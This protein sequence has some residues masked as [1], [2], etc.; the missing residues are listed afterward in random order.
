[1]SL[2]NNRCLYYVSVSCAAR[3]IEQGA[4]HVSGLLASLTYLCVDTFMLYIYIY[5]YMYIYICMYVCVY[6]YA[7]IER[8]R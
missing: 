5:I 6:I 8:E 3:N 7:Y 4:T 1:M 2:L